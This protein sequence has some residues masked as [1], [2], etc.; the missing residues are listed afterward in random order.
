[1]KPMFVFCA[2]LMFPAVANAANYKVDLGLISDYEE[3]RPF[4]DG[5]SDLGNLE[6][7]RDALES[8]SDL[9]NLR[10]FLQDIG[11]V[12]FNDCPSKIEIDGVERTN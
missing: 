3:L 11:Y 6:D 9:E 4:V 12:E 2:A 1:M 5:C 8:A 7:H 10:S